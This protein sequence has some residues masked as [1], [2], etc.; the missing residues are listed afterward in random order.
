MSED[1]KAILVKVERSKGKVKNKQKAANQGLGLVLFHANLR[2]WLV[3]L[4]F[5]SAQQARFQETQGAK[6]RHRRT[7]SL[8]HRKGP[9]RLPQH[10]M[11][12][13][14]RL[15]TITKTSDC[16]LLYHSICSVSKAKATLLFMILGM[17]G[18]KQFSIY[19]PINKG[20]WRNA[21]G[22]SQS[23]VQPAWKTEPGCHWTRKALRT[24][25]SQVNTA[26][27]A[28]SPTTEETPPPQQR[29]LKTTA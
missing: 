17:S 10:F 29:W 2:C 27:K 18:S 19:C 6:G 8:E 13:A 21:L 4:R 26:K 14:H 3:S 28:R 9:R 25:V 16:Y 23:S 11:E 12:D 5:P 24:C 1:W 7:T 20:Y 22:K 15:C